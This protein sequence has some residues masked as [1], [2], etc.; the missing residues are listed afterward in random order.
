MSCWVIDTNVAI[1]ANGGEYLDTDP[2]C[3]EATI[4]FFEK[5]YEGQK[6]AI[7]DAFLILDE[8]MSHLNPS[9]QPGSGDKFMKWV[10]DNQGNPEYCTRVAITA[11]ER[12]EFIEFPE[13]IELQKFDRSDRKFVAVAVKAPYDTKIANATDSDWWIFKDKL[14]KN[15][16]EID[17]VCKHRFE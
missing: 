14:R 10:Y 8:Y 13:D 4:V 12:R 15:G 16:I 17:F 9:G 1:V 3:V 11:H 7:D 5:I 2:S 6:V